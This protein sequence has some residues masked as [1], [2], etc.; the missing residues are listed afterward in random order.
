MTAISTQLPF[1]PLWALLRQT[2]RDMSYVGIPRLLSRSLQGCG[3]CMKHSSC[4]RRAERRGAQALE[5]CGVQTDLLCLVHVQVAANRFHVDHLRFGRLRELQDDEWAEL[6]RVGACTE[7]HNL[8]RDL[9]LLA[10]SGQMIQ[11]PAHHLWSAH[12]APDG[13]FVQNC[14]ELRSVVSG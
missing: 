12:H 9:P 2:A 13:S 11:L 7:G 6:P 5:C 4:L 10:D 1:C 3:C 8:E 14:P